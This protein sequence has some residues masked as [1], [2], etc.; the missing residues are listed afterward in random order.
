MKL[1]TTAF[2]LLCIGVAFGRTPE[3]RSPWKWT[4]SFPTEFQAAK[5]AHLHA[6]KF[7]KGKFAFQWTGRV[8]DM[9][10]DLGRPDYVSRQTFLD[11]RKPTAPRPGKSGTFRYDF[12]D[13]VR[14]YAT[15]ADMVRVNLAIVQKNGKVSELLYK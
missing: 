4:R 7:V 9:L 15:T 14:V 13:N 1:F 3:G 11:V 6:R 2:L 5:S 12:A 8:A 10:K